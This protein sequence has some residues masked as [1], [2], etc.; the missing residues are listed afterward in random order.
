MVKLRL[1]P[2][3]VAPES[4]PWT[5]QFLSLLFHVLPHKKWVKLIGFW[6]VIVDDW[7]RMLMWVTAS[8]CYDIKQFPESMGF[9]TQCLGEDGTYPLARTPV[10]LGKACATVVGPLCTS[11]DP[12]SYWENP[13]L[14]ILGIR[15]CSFSPWHPLQDLQLWCS[16]SLLFCL[17][18]RKWMSLLWE[19]TQARSEQ[20]MCTGGLLRGFRHCFVIIFCLF[21][22]EISLLRHGVAHPGPLVIAKEFVPFPR[23]AL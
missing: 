2:R 15:S 9:L 7:V 4:L 10:L 3:Q 16:C 23:W 22:K 17:F 5:F 6:N 18:I 11:V 14:K 21:L 13:F 12:V 8:Q 20:L 19:E 1:E